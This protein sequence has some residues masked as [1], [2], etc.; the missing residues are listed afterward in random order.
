MVAFLDP[1]TRERGDTSGFWI[2]E[3]LKTDCGLLRT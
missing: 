2:I 3:S 1:R